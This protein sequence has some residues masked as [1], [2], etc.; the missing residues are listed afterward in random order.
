MPFYDLSRGLFQEVWIA[1]QAIEDGRL[2]EAADAT[3]YPWLPTGDAALDEAQAIMRAAA[4]KTGSRTHREERIVLANQALALSSKCSDAFLEL[5]RSSL[6]FPS[7][8]P[9]MVYCSR[10]ARTSVTWYAVTTSR[11]STRSSVYRCVLCPVFTLG[12]APVPLWPSP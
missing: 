10:V 2:Q 11:F 1:L 12:R 5:V 4:R 7:S 8:S 3:K 6:A 9:H